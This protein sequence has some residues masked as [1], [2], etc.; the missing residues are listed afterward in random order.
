MSTD[1]QPLIRRLVPRA[2]TAEQALHAVALLQQ[3]IAAIWC[4]HGEKMGRAMLA[5]EPPAIQ[6]PQSPTQ[7]AQ[8]GRRSG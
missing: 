6:Q 5:E 8:A 7:P 4:V 1:L 3:V 2:W